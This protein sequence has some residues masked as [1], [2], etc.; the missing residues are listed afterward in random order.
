MLKALLFDL[1][2]TLADTDRYH[3]TAFEMVFRERGIHL[4]PDIYQQHISGKHNPVIMAEWFPELSEREQ[5]ALAEH[6]EATYR[7]LAS[8]VTALPGLYRVLEWARAHKLATGLV[9]NADRPNVDFVLRALKLTTQFDV[10]VLP[11]GIPGK[12][13]PAPYQIALEALRVAPHEVIVFED[14]RS[15]IAAAKAA[16]CQVIGVTTGFPAETLLEL[17]CQMAIDTFEDAA[18]WEYLEKMTRD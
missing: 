15:G 2:G 14:S 5:Y 3:A 7:Q 10:Q 18:L 13:N 1:D 11:E 12:P 4:T 8:T 17:G 9:T 16:G 6:K